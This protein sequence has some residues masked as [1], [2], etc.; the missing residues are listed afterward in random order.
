MSKTSCY[1]KVFIIGYGKVVDE[2][3]KYVYQRQKEYGYLIE[4]IEYETEPF[5]IAGKICSELGIPCCRINDKRELTDYFLHM[6][7]R[8]LIISAS[9][10]YLFPAKITENPDYT[11]INFHNALLP[12]FPGRNA[13]SWVIFEN[14]TETGITWHY[15]TKKIDG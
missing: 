12:K 8:C 4:Y 14:E 10:N 1:K 2:I 3:I 15:V 7:D 11:I 9:N 6:A 13:P 5:K